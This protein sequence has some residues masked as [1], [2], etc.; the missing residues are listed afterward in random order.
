MAIRFVLSDYIEKAM[1]YAVYDKLEDGTFAGRI[2]Q[3]KGVVAFARDLRKCEAE[4]RSTLEDWIFVGL[5]LGHRLPIVG[6]IN[7][8]KEPNHERMGAYQTT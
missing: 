8:N 6:G 7:L 3:C 5:K 4:L 1:T 2:P